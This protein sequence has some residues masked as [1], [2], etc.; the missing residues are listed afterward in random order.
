MAVERVPLF[1][2]IADAADAKAVL[3]SDGAT[4]TPSTAGS[5]I[6][7]RGD[8]EAHAFKLGRITAGGTLY[9]VFIIVVYA[10]DVR[11]AYRYLL[12]IQEITGPYTVWNAPQALLDFLSSLR[13]S[14]TP[15][16]TNVLAGDCVECI[17]ALDYVAGGEPDGSEDQIVIAA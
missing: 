14:G 3:E 8:Y 4:I 9:K 1:V 2:G 15:G 13:G 17:D 10:G 7:E 16:S 11:R 6:L 12:D 5:W